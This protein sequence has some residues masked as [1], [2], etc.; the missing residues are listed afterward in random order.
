MAR[1]K[2]N[3]ESYKLV[4]KWRK[5]KMSRKSFK[6][7]SFYVKCVFF[8]FVQCMCFLFTKRVYIAHKNVQCFKTERK[9]ST[10][11]SLYF[12]NLLVTR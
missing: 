11:L 9:E 10:R 3:R 12:L 7:I 2:K 8:G 4:W 6:S 1:K 5:K